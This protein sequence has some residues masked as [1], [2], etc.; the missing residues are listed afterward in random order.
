MRHLQLIPP[1]ITMKL[2]EGHEDILTP[3]AVER[4]RF[5]TTQSC[6]RCGGRCRKIGDFRTMWH[7]GEILPRF[8]LEC[9]ACG[10]EFNP[11]NGMIVKLGNVGQAVEPAIPILR[12]D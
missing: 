2:L 9:L 12:K 5:Y 7:R 10:C 1:E 8:Y 6:P 11:H 3:A 4:E